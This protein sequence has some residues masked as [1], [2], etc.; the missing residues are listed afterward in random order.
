MTALA[1]CALAAVAPSRT[2]PA[3][4]FIKERRSVM[5]FLAAFLATTD[6]SA[7]PHLTPRGVGLSKHIDWRATSCR[8]TRSGGEWWDMSS[9][10][11]KILGECAVEPQSVFGSGRRRRLDSRQAWRSPQV[12]AMRC[13]NSASETSPW[14]RKDGSQQRKDCRR[15]HPRDCSHNSHQ[16][17]RDLRKGQDLR[18]RKGHHRKVR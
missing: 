17:S 10:A 3:S 12:K 18:K 4:D 16:P 1:R 8:T 11:I 2:A 5:R 7:S 9:G 13:R 14:M 6:G 15:S